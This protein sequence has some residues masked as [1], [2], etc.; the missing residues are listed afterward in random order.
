MRRGGR[1][2]RGGERREGFVPLVLPS[3]PTCLRTSARLP[4]FPQMKLPFQTQGSDTVGV[5]QI[6]PILHVRLSMDAMYVPISG[7]KW[8]RIIHRLLG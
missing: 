2:E 3:V 5:V 8:P 4:A 7:S 6:T 1:E